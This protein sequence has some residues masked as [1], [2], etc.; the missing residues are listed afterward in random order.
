MGKLKKLLFVSLF[1]AAAIVSAVPKASAVDSCAICASD[2]SN[3]FQCCRCDGGT[4]GF[5]L[6]ACKA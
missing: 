1:T 4:I 3:C 6:E 5:C 2:P